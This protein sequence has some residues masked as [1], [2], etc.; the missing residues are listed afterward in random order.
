MAIWHI[1][2]SENELLQLSESKGYPLSVP[3]KITHSRRKR[4]WLSV[5][6]MLM[7]M[8][9]GKF[10]PE[11]AYSEHG[12]PV[13]KKAPYHISVSHSGF[14]SAVIKHSHKAVGI[15]IE[16][17]FDKIDRV[18]HKFLSGDEK[19]ISLRHEQNYL[20]V[21]WGAKETVYKIEGRKG[22]IFKEE[23]LCEDFEYEEKGKLK[24]KHI[25]QNDICY[26]CL[27]YE[28]LQEFMLVYGMDTN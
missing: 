16:A 17:Y 18:K 7:D 5:R 15:D 8:L 10:P 4:E 22:V 13:L 12:K 28:H 6:I 19:K 20:P 24:V 3:D 26:Y 1:T 21:I 14:Y 27:F 2:E 11:I 25:K 9:E 23:I